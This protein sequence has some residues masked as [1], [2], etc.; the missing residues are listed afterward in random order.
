MNEYKRA[1]ELKEETIANRRFCMKTRRMVCISQRQ[2]DFLLK[3]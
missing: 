1:L 3:N 2:K